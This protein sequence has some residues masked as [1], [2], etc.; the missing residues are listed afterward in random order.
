PGRSAVAD[1]FRAGGGH[2]VSRGRARRAAGGARLPVEMVL[3]V[4]VTGIL[5]ALVVPLPPWLLD[6]GL[7]LNLLAAASLLL[8]ALQA[9]SGLELRALATLLLGA[10]LL[11]LALDGSA[12]RVALVEGH[13]G[14]IIQAFG[15]FVVRGD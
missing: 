5:A 8:A 4:A 13:A 14:Q 10:T 7:A 12:P 15:V 2:V 3:P 9:R 1:A 11:R 6:F